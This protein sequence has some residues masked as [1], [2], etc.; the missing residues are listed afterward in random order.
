MPSGESSRTAQTLTKSSLDHRDLRRDDFWASIPAYEKVPGADFHTHAFQSR[1]TVTNLR[2][3]RE[4]LQGLVPEAFYDDVAQGLGRA[5]MAL[6]ISPYLLSLVDWE[7]PYH[8]PIRT[9][10]LPVASQQVPDHPELLH[11]GASLPSRS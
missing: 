2:Q 6:R 11:R 10:F 8:D 7:N 9:Q 4:T 3:L 1:H 5:P